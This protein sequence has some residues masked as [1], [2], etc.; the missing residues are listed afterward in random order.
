MKIWNDYITSISEVDGY[1]N[2]I[3]SYITDRN[4]ILDQGGQKNSPPYTKKMGGHVTFDKQLEEEVGP[5]S[6]ETRDTLEPRIWEDDKLRPEIRDNLLKIAKDFIEGLPVPVEIKDIT[7]TGSLANYNWSNYSD[8]D[9]HI[10]VDFLSIDENRVLVK[11]FFDNARMRWNDKHD[12]KV[13]GYDVEIYVEDARES[14]KSS[15]VYSILKDDWNKEPKRFQSSIDF[16]AARRKADDVEFQINIVDNLVIAEKYRSA[17]R[18]VE[19]LK[20]KIR[21]MRRAGLESQKQE[22]SVENI[23]FK[24]LRRNGILDMLDQLKT[25]AYDSLL[26]IREE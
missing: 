10:I 16:N 13:K 9:L 24:I 23:T 12:I 14:H 5:D 18:N 7:L 3:K 2:R 25:Q 15:G 22:F 26:N 21:N 4:A 20:R 8:V 19:R 11:S 6:F 17:L 1:R